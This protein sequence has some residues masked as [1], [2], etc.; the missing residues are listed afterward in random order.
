MLVFCKGDKILFTWGKD[1]AVENDKYCIFT[2][3]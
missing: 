3:S 2:V 1:G